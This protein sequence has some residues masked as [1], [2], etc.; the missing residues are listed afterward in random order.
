MPINKN[1]PV[2]KVI[3]DFVHSSNKKFAS[4]SRKQRIKRAL[5]AYYSMHNEAKE[6]W[7]KEGEWSKQMKKQE[8]EFLRAKNRSKKPK[9]E[10]KIN[11]SVEK[12]HDKEH[13]KKGTILV[14]L[15]NKK[16]SGVRR[17]NKSDYDPKKHNLAEENNMTLE[18]SVSR[19]HFREVANTVRAI[20]DP[21]KRQEFA[22]HHAD[23]FSHANPRFSHDKFHAACGTKTRSER[24]MMTRMGEET[25][26][27]EGNW[28]NAAKKVK[29]N[30]E[31]GAAPKSY[32]QPG[33]QSKAEKREEAA[34][35]IAAYRKKRENKD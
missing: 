3:D 6:P 25:E 7:K 33:E 27:D 24:G 14:T 31:I 10:K 21:A 19:K 30:K 34:K 15:K 5:G 11:E 23:I 32:R 12:M 35:L 20:E 4:D 28:S 18:E 1:T 29:M 9:D 17:I 16:D 2:E 8:R 22:D 13:N 26:L